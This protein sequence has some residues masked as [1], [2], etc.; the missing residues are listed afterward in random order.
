MRIFL[1]SLILL[2]VVLES[3]GQ[4][5]DFIVIKKRNN[6]TLKT[7]IPGSYITGSTYNNFQLNGVIKDIRNDS[8]FIQQ[9]ET[10]LMPTE[11]GQTIDTLFYT[12]GI[13]YQSI[14]RFYYNRQFTATMRKKGF[15]QVALPKIMIIGGVGFITLELVNTVYRKEKLNSGNR[16]TVLGVAAAVAAAGILWEYLKAQSDKAGGKYKV[17]YVRSHSV[18]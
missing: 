18:K 1:F 11:F 8:L 16:L 17:V 5:S 6:R 3:N 12:Y 10:K 14:K 2:S 13:P 15:V 4:Q 7:Y 9:Q